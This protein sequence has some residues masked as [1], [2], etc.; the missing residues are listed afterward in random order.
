MGSTEAPAVL[1]RRPGL[2]KETV[3]SWIA[4]VAAARVRREPPASFPRLPDLPA[5]RYSDL[6]FYQERRIYH[7][8]EELDRRI[9]V[10]RIPEPLGVAPVLGEWLRGL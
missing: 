8:H 5:G 9:G 1:T 6:A 10:D 2:D 4:G 3:E 7:W